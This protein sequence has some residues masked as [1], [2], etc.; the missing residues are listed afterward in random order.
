M[1]TDIVELWSD[2]LS[3]GVITQIH[4]L[5]TSSDPTHAF[6]LNP[7]SLL[8]PLSCASYSCREI[9]IIALHRIRINVSAISTMYLY[10]SPSLTLSTHIIPPCL[11]ERRIVGCLLSATFRKLVHLDERSVSAI[12]AGYI[13]TPWS[14]VTCILIRDFLMNWIYINGSLG[15]S[16]PD[17]WR[18][19]SFPRIGVENWRWIR[20]YI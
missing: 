17:Q 12:L 9:W 8:F 16:C 1:Y 2:F 20:N 3:F 11:Q 10:W 19:Q 4:S 15:K 7:V 5:N 6:G 18:S 14:K 13:Y